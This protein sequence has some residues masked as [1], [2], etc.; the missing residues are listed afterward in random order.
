MGWQF[1]ERACN[2]LCHDANDLEIWQAANVLVQ[3]HGDNATQEAEKHLA[4]VIARG[5]ADGEAAWRSVLN[6]IPALL[7]MKPG[8]GLN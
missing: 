3:K 5:D 1:G 4:A 7:A 8:D 2:L 6:V